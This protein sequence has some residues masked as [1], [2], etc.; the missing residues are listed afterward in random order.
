[1]ES[2]KSCLLL[3]MAY[4]IFDTM[5]KGGDSPEIHEEMQESTSKGKYYSLFQDIW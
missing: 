2:L 3:V 5:Q 1:M 4:I